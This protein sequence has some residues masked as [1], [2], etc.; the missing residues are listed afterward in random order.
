M[1]KKAIKDICLEKKINKNKLPKN[2][3]KNKERKTKICYQCQD[4]N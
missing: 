2:I 4:G 3:N 1:K